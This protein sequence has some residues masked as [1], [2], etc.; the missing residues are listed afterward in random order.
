MSTWA[1]CGLTAAILAAAAEPVRAQVGRDGKP[2]APRPATKDAAPPGKTKFAA[3]TRP[4]ASELAAWI[5]AQFAALWVKEN[6][7]PA[8]IA[9]DAA[10]L[11]RACLDLIGTIPSVSQARD[12]FADATPD[13]RNKLVERLVT[14]TRHA[15]H[16]ARVW[17][18]I[19]IPPSSPGI[20]FAANVEPWLR[21]ELAKNIGFDKLARQIIAAQPSGGVSPGAFY[22]AVGAEPAPSAGA[23]V[24]VFLGARIGC[25]ECH[26]HPF[27]SWTQDDFWGTAAFFAN[28]AR[29]RRGSAEPTKGVITIR[30]P[31]SDKVYQ[32]RFLGGATAVVP[33]DKSPREFLADWIVR[34]PDFAA[35]CV[36][37]MWQHLF[38]SGLVHPVDGLDLADRRPAILDE[39]ALR[40]AA[41]DFDLRW[42][43]AALCQ[44]RLYQRASEQRPK[45]ARHF[46]HMTLKTLSS[47]QV[48]D[49]LEQALA[50][51]IA[52]TPG[53]P[54]Y[55]NRRR[56]LIDKL[57]ESAGDSPEEYRAGI[58]QA[59]ALMNGQL[60]AGGTDLAQSRTLR[61]VLEAP[62]LSPAGKLE[63]LYLAALTRP[64]RR[65]ELHAMLDYVTR[66]QTKPQQQRAYADVFWSLLNSPEFVLNR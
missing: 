2:D 43:L 37:R 39:L 24:R 60:I 36:N 19:M 49:V 13:K 64:P 48:F 3:P 18:R 14:D 6:L 11:R 5:D 1:R 56:Q 50:L 40:F 47:E 31:G 9:D 65:D 45:Q 23:A 58:L 38:G 22:Q 12:F 57:N 21:D 8:P 41:A 29:S 51:P 7:A 44:T 25:A 55:D 26:D 53:A 54:R 61:A 16:M 52:A 15:G 10:F 30:R 62:F 20:F 17:R 42:L 66:P 63:A 59:L 32:G 28:G 46:T 4:P 33:D 34:H 27:A 35:T